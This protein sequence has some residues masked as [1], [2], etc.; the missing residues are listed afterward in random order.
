[1]AGLTKSALALSAIAALT[2]AG[3]KDQ[4]AERKAIEAQNAKVEAAEAQK[5]LA[6]RVD[7]AAHCHAGIK[8]KAGAIAKAKVGDAGTYT[9]FYRDQLTAAIGDQTMPAD[10]DKPALSKASVDDYLAWADKTYATSAI[11]GPADTG[12]FVQ[13]CVTT[14]SEMGAGPLAK[15]QPYQRLEKMQ[16]VKTYIDAS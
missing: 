15:L 11:G 7:R 10:G 14:A 8:W 4:E 1:M 13:G 5:K 12:T 2:L 6:G 3:C 16:W 9:D